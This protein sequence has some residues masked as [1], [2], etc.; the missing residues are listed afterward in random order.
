MFDDD[1]DAAVPLY[2]RSKKGTSSRPPVT[3]LV[4][5]V[6]DNII[7]DPD[8]QELAAAEAVLAVSVASA[9]DH[10]GM[11]LLAIRTIDPPSRLTPPGVPNSI[12]PATA[13]QGAGSGLSSQVA[14]TGGSSTASIAGAPANAA[15]EVMIEK[16]KGNL[17]SPP[18][19]GVKRR[20]ITKIIKAVVGEGGVAWEVLDGLANVES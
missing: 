4:M 14:G 3:L 13:S 11:K 2:S 7:F 6:G 20:L 12:N 10:G 19:G 9:S 17:W 15:Q 1:W 18:R 5:T 8:K 16:E